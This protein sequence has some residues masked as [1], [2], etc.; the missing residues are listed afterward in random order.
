MH[1]GEAHLGGLFGKVDF[2]L[3]SIKDAVKD[4]VVVVGGADP[5]VVPSGMRDGVLHKTIILS[6]KTKML[7]PQTGTQ[8]VSKTRNKEGLIVEGH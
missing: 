7:Q 1:L 3:G 2:A 8:S 6:A 4:G 5:Q